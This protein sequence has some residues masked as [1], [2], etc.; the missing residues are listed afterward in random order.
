MPYSQNT[1]HPPLP[2]PPSLP[3]FSPPRRRRQWQLADDEESEVVLLVSPASSY[4]SLSLYHLSLSLF[5]FIHLWVHSFKG[6][7]CVR[8]RF[9]FFCCCCCLIDCSNQYINAVLLE[10][11]CSL[12]W[13]RF[14]SQSGWANSLVFVRRCLSNR[15]QKTK[16]LR[17]KPFGIESEVSAFF[18]V[19]SHCLFWKLL[20]FLCLRC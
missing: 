8:F 3:H 4:L 5:F 20:V 17:F 7:V 16:R 6:K 2:L 9:V 1:P 10:K 15:V 18:L 19:E 13:I 14:V 12:Q 11:W